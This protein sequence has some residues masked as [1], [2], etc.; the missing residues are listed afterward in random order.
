MRTHRRYINALAIVGTIQTPP[1]GNQS[2]SQSNSSDGS[3][4]SLLSIKRNIII[5]SLL[6]TLE[7]AVMSIKIEFVAICSYVF[8]LQRL[9]I[10]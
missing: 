9:I 8:S 5:D 7:H 1:A 3:H 6:A 10:K 2:A 4:K